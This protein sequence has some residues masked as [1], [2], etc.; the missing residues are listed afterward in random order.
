MIDVSYHERRLLAVDFKERLHRATERGLQAR[1]ARAREAAAQALSE[2]ECRRLHSAYR[3]RLTEH[4]EACLK[5]LAENFPGF[6][7]ET[8]VDEKGWG[9]AIRRDDLSLNAGKRDN[10]FSRL[11]MKISPYS[12]FH[13]L[14][15]SAKGAIR[16]KEN[17]S[18]NHYQLLKDADLD[19]FEQTIE[20]WTLDYAE[21]FAADNG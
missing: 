15:L 4:I 3:L 1:D 7:F 8:V 18:R 12:E 20:Q 2:E 17:F 11:V 19:S 14:D 9:A 13:V 21:Q 5:Q 6:N 16:N 10:L